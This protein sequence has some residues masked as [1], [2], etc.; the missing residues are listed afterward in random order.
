MV[1]RG[2]H[3]VKLR[4]GW[5]VGGVPLTVLSGPEYENSYVSRRSQPAQPST[6][7]GVGEFGALPK[8]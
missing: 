8:K 6:Y 7:L 5:Q 4:T 3:G 2:G 1:A